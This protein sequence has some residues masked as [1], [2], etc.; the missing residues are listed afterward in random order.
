MTEKFEF[1]KCNICGNT[2]QVLFSGAGEL[3][4]CGEAMQKL[5]TQ[6]GEGNELSE[7][8]IPEIEHIDNKKFVRLSKH[9]MLTE[10]YIQFIQVLSKDKK[11]M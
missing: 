3:V 1:Y 9:P 6:C 5:K 8:H 2:V 7:K 10:H 4:C 11:Y